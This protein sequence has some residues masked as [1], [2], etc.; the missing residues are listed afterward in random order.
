MFYSHQ[1][2]TLSVGKNNVTK[3]LLQFCIMLAMYELVSVSGRILHFLIVHNNHL[4]TAANVT[5]HSLHKICIQISRGYI[6]LYDSIIMYDF[7]LAVLFGVQLSN[8]LFS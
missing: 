1:G 7:L 5:E 3:L 8:F 2:S 4:L 6:M